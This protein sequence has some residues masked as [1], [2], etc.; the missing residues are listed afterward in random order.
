MLPMCNRQLGCNRLR[1]NINNGYRPVRCRSA[2]L[3]ATGDL[4]LAALC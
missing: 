4:E 1:H 2:E 3:A